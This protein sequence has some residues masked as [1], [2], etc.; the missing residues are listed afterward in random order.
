MTRYCFAFVC[1]GVMRRMSLV[2]SARANRFGSMLSC[3]L[4]L[5]Q[6]YG[7]SLDVG[8]IRARFFYKKGVVLVIIESQRC[9]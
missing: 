1:V 2:G 6:L 8:P 5:S 4:G 9:R 3:L 7:P